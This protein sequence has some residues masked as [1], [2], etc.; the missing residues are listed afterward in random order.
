[1]EVPD[2]TFLNQRVRLLV[3]DSKKLSTLHDM[4]TFTNETN[5]KYVQCQGQAPYSG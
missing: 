3:S 1:M 4:S 2:T 5:C